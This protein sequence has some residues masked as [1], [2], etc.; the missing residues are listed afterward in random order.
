MDRHKAIV[1]IFSS[2]MKANGGGDLDLT[3]YMDDKLYDQFDDNI[4]PVEGHIKNRSG[5]KATTGDA[6]GKASKSG[7]AADDAPAPASPSSTPG[8]V[9]DPEEA[10][11]GATTATRAAGKRK[12]DEV[13]EPQDDPRPRRKART[14]KKTVNHGMLC[15]S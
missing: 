1:N 10:A 11:G 7:E 8:D 2:V 5:S 14:T 13:S 4:V 6:S 12:A 15:P 3:H 9:T